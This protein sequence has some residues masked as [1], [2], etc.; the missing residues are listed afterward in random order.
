MSDGK[1]LFKGDRLSDV[2]K[3]VGTLSVNGDVF[4]NEVA[5]GLAPGNMLIFGHGFSVLYGEV[6]PPAEVRRRLPDRHLLLSFQWTAAGLF[7]ALESNA[8]V[9]TGRPVSAA[10]VDAPTN[11][12]ARGVSTAVTPAPCWTS[13]LVSAAAL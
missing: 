3:V 2:S 1:I 12:R 10:N 4:V 11:R 7:G 9:A 8:R 13:R 6:E 5:D